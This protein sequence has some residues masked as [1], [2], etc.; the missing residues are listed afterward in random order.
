ML[1][2]DEFFSGDEGLPGLPGAPGRPGIGIK[3]DPGL[4]GRPGNDGFP[5]IPGQ[6]G[7]ILFLQSY[8]NT[9]DLKKNLQKSLKEYSTWNFNYVSI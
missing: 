4:P 8:F 6:K 7:I 2:F 1:T 5:G 9:T 3:G